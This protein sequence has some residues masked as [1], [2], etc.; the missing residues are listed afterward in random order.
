MLPFLRQVS[1]GLQTSWSLGCEHRHCAL[2]GGGRPSRAGLQPGHVRSVPPAL[3]GVHNV[4]ERLVTTLKDEP[5]L[6]EGL[7]VV[8]WS[9]ASKELWVW[10]RTESNVGLTT[11]F[12]E[13]TRI[14]DLYP[15][16]MADDISCWHLLR[17]LADAGWHYQDE[18]LVHTATTAKKVV[19]P[20]RRDYLRAL[21]MSD[22]L[23]QQGATEIHSS[24]HNAYYMALI[25]VT[26]KAIVKPN[27]LVRDYARM[28][29][30]SGWEGSLR[31]TRQVAEGVGP[32]EPDVVDTSSDISDDDPVL[33]AEPD[34]H[35]SELPN[36]A[37]P[38]QR[39]LAEQQNLK[40]VRKG[41]HLTHD[42]TP[43]LQVLL[44]PQNLV[45]LVFLD[46]NLCCL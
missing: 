3:S 33:H 41:M 20:A 21:L 2:E 12:S 45:Q 9:I 8:P 26:N 29:Q 30:G 6:A 14:F 31:S 7:T 17:K 27:L 1:L 5:Q 13:A 32:V 16:F 38:D 37:E 43:A 28:L 44:V 35:E 46:S 25:H 39:L 40:M 36:Q 22:M 42:A 23:F 19:R 10:K 34:V 4:V 11:T 18:T 15:D 24:Q